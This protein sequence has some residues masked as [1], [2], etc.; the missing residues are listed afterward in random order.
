MIE[1][2][3]LA[4]LLL[5]LGGIATYWRNARARTRARERMQR[6]AEASEAAAARAAE[7]VPVPVAHP[8]LVRHRFVPWM[9]GLVTALVLHFA[10]G[11]ALPFVIAVGLIVSLQAGQLEAY[12][13]A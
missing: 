8:Y 5:G 9:F 2:F 12:L 11:W 3:V 6:A 10:F 7:A 13:A 1:T 4:G